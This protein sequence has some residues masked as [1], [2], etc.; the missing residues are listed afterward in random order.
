MVK[1]NNQH[2]VLV[3]CIPTTELW[4]PCLLSNQISLIHEW[5]IN[6]GKV[7]YRLFSLQMGNFATDICEGGAEMCME[8]GDF[9]LTFKHWIMPIWY[10]K[11]KASLNSNDVNKYGWCCVIHICQNRFKSTMARTAKTLICDFNQT[12]SYI[13]RIWTIEGRLGLKAISRVDNFDNWQW[14]WKYSMIHIHLLNRDCVAT[15]FSRNWCFSIQLPIRLKC[16]SNNVPVHVIRFSIY[17]NCLYNKVY[18][19]SSHY[20]IN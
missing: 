2:D 1:Q 17:Q 14:I 12:L 5:K 3:I 11:G 8:W 9:Q 18:P 16:I 6:K 4:M 10:Y 20:C 13:S 19:G 15:H 7:L